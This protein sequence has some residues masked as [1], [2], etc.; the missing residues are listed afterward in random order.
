VPDGDQAAYA[1]AIAAEFQGQRMYI[2][3]LSGG[4]VGISAGDGSFLWRYNHPAN[5]TANCSTPIYRD[6]VVFAASGYGTGG[7]AVRLSGK[8]KNMTAKELFFTKNMKNHHGGMVQL[9][10][11]VYG[12]D[13]GLL[14]CLS[15]KTGKVIW[16]E[17]RPGKGSIAAG[18]G[19]LIYRNEGGPIY[20]VQATPTKYVQLGRFEPP[21]KSGKPSWPHPVIADGKLYIRDQDYLFC[22]N[23]KGK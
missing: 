3:F 16:A 6:G 10:D 9:G 1:S 11:Y 14:T 12:S 19:K 13:E 7:G 18:D 2:Q 21:K 17:R 20:L 5:G 15:L 4:V 8:G 23:I 22:Y